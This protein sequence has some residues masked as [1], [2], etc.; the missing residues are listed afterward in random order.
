MAIEFT[1]QEWDAINA[2]LNTHPKKYGFPEPTEGSVLIGSFNIRKL[3]AVRKRNAATWN[4]LARICK[5]FDLL[6]IQE[7][8]DNME[9]I[10][11]LLSR[12]GDEYGMVISDMTGTFPGAQGLGERLAFI[13]KW[14]VVS[15]GE[16]VS[17]VT[18]DRS[19]IIEILLNNLDKFNKASAD[20]NKKMDSY[21]KGKR[22]TKPDFAMPVFL[23]FIRQPFCVSFRINGKAGSEPYLFMAI[24]AHLI[25]GETQDRK[26][27]FEALMEWITSRVSQEKK[28]YYPNFLLCGDLNL[29]FDDPVE[30]F[31][32]IE[33]Y[34]KTFNGGLGNKIHVN[35]PFLDP[36]FPLT[37]QYTSNVLQNQRYDQI[38]LF[39]KDTRLPAFD[40]NSTMGTNAEGPDYGVFNFAEL[41]CQAINHKSFG[42]LTKKEK[43]SF[44]ARFEHKV[45]DH[46]PIWLKLPLP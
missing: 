14:N 32:E 7:V 39:F 25:Y 23:S 35:F 3:G 44:V 42:T 41:F 5:Q 38:G 37:V 24:N 1:P 18:Y 10:K 19:K 2:E 31:P 11:K 21:F 33:K 20:Y 9:G 36:H 17:D 43:E 16:V 27:E 12:L 34:M 6:A 4:F 22:K 28:T 40:Q 8:Q 15:R 46:M 29:N 13:F 30:D 26:R 45:S